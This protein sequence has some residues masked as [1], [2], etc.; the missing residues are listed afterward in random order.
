MT[1]V[2]FAIGLAFLVPFLSGCGKESVP[3]DL[4]DLYPATIAVTMDGAPLGNATVTL[5][6]AEGGTWS[7]GGTTDA[8][9]LAA[10]KTQMKY[11]GVAAGKYKVGVNKMSDADNPSA[12]ADTANL[13]YEE[14]VK[15][16]QARP[17]VKSL[18][19][20]G[21]TVAKLSPLEVEVTAG[22]ENKL[23]VNLDTKNPPPPIPGAR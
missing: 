19:P 18:V 4:P 15:A 9:G 17:A 14:Q 12:P 16:D 22:G 8:S 13:S 6:P 3:A 21:Y 7:A 1:R 23:S 11:D 5:A 2:C 10:L 20:D